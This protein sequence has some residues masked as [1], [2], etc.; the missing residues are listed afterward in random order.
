MEI[1][2]FIPEQPGRLPVD[3][4]KNSIQ[5][6]MLLEAE[7]MDQAVELARGCPILEGDGTVEVRPLGAPRRKT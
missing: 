6:Y 2:V 3:E 4:V 5:G 7:D 1:H